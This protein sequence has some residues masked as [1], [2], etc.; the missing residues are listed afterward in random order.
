MAS[1][2]TSDGGDETWRWMGCHFT[3]TDEELMDDCLLNKVHNLPL[4]IPPGF[5]IPEMA[6]YK[7]APWELMVR[8]SYLPTGVSYCFVRVP[9]SKARDNRL[10]RKTRGGRWVANGKPRDI[11]HQDRR[12]AIAGTRRSLKF[13]KDSGDPR[14]KNK[15]DRSLGLQWIMHEYRL[16]PSLYETIPSYETEEIILCRIQHKGRGAADESDGDSLP[17]KAPSVTDTQETPEPWMAGPSTQSMAIDVPGCCWVQCGTGGTEEV[18]WMAA[19]P[20]IQGAMADVFGYYCIPET[21]VMGKELSC[22]SPP[23]VPEAWTC[24]DNV[25]FLDD[26]DLVAEA[27]FATATSVAPSA[28]EPWM[29]GPSTQSMAIDVPGCCWVQCGTGATEEVSLMA[30]APAIPMADV[31]GCYCVPETGVLGKE[32]S[33]EGPPAVPEALTCDDIFGFLDDLDVVAEATLATATSVAPSATEPWK[34]APP[35]TPGE[36]SHCTA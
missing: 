10:K 15:K 22:E 20:A 9:R 5:S 18:S 33:C 32:P 35:A 12:A 30:A 34:E 19:A 27:T 21:G 28:T 14:K 11:P 6:V 7:K 3:P 1:E 16:H 8:S 25:G 26:L 2:N 24:D 13:F 23:A 4:R 17:A 36:Q 29:A 31:F